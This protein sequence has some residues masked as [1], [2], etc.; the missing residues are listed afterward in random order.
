MNEHIHPLEEFWNKTP[1][2]RAKVN[3]LQND[4]VQVG[5]GVD[6]TNLPY[7]YCLHLESKDLEL[8]VDE[9]LKDNDKYNFLRIKKTV[10]PLRTLT[11]DEIKEKIFQTIK[12]SK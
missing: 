5:S 2:L 3:T 7:Y 10:I 4:Y 8:W 6:I 1:E 12:A 9:A 11:I